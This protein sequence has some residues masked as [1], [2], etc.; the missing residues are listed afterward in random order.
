MKTFTITMK[1]GNEIEL[2]GVGLSEEEIYKYLKENIKV[3]EFES[4]EREDGY[5][6]QIDEID[7]DLIYF[8]AYG[9]GEYTTFHTF[10]F[11]KNMALFISMS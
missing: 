2:D 3:E 8:D 6:L 7:G 5:G 1:N 10:D 9:N 11:H 4:I